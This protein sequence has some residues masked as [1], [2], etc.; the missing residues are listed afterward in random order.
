[1]PAIR[2][3]EDFKKNAPPGSFDGQLGT[4]PSRSNEPSQP[5]YEPG[6][7]GHRRQMIELAYIGT[8]GMKREDAEA[9]YDRQMREWDAMQ[10]NQ[11]A[12]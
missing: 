1:M 4:R 8:M 2:R 12:G 9:L 3:A 10:G 5:D 11:P 6:T 7:P